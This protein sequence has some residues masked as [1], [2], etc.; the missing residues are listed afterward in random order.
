MNWALG[1]AIEVI[2]LKKYA[3]NRFSITSRNII[4]IISC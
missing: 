2:V 1:Q 4:K 3:F